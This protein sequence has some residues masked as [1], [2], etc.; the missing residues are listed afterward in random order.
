MRRSTR[1]QG[2]VLIEL[3][4]I[5]P[6][7]ISLIL[8]AVH[9]GYLFYLYNG[10]E[11]SVRDG[12]RYAASRTYTTYADY[13]TVVQKVVVYGSLNGSTPLVTDLALQDSNKKNMVVVTP[14]PNASGVRPER[15]K[16]EITGY[17]YVGILSGLLGET[18]L[19]G[20]PAVEVPFIGRYAPP[21][22]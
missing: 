11:K 18:L 16:V 12:A 10:L 2:S 5:L 9:F 7:A 15:I 22:S 1:K 6:V 17:K 21:A 13:S 3:A 19:V 20:K 14:I 4:L 8:G